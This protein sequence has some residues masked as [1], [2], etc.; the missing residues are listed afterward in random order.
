[1]AL[2]FDLL[3]AIVIAKAYVTQGLRL[4]PG[5][6]Q[7]HGPL[8]HGSWPE[9]Q[10][11]LPWL[12]ATAEAAVAATARPRFPD[13]GPAPLGFYPIVNR[14]DWLAK[15]L[16]L[17]VTTAQLRVKD[18]TGEALEAEVAQAVALA[19]QSDCRL[20]INDYWQLALKYGAYGVHLG[21]SDLDTADLDALAAA[22]L[23]LGVSTHCYAEVARGLAVKP[24]YLAVG[25]VFHTTTKAMYF[26][27][28]GLE[29]VRRWRRSLPGYP[30][31]AIAGIFLEN[32]REVL[33]TGVDSLA[34]VR[35]IVHADAEGMLAERVAQWLALFPAQPEPALA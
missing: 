31:V 34:V 6:G 32:A 27:P 2:G 14:A 29:A 10:G 3:D 28:Q 13:V 19:K 21:Q 9:T 23:R 1:V 4:A 15:L 7:G 11:D 30:L 35:D 25:P 5:L 22:G 24:S 8:H 20:F 17:G 33:D 12:T 16:P 18:L 26:A